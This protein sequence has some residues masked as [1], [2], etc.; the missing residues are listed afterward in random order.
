MP[1]EQAVF[2]A[3]IDIGKT[4][5]KVLLIDLSTG[6]EV[7]VRKTANIALAGPPFPHF[8]EPALWDFILASLRDIGAMHRIDAISITTHGACGA[9]VDAN[10][11]LVL[12]VLD[13]E[14]VGPDEL[15][16]QYE[17]LRPPFAETGSPRLPIGLNLGAQLFWLAQRFAHEFS[18][19]VHFLTW[20]QY[21]A[22]KLT[23]VAASEPTSLGCHTDLWDPWNGRFS[24]LVEQQDWQHLFP[25]VRKASAVLGPLKAEVAASTRLD[26][27]I[28]VH[29]GIHD[30]NASL[31]PYLDSTHQHFSV[32]STGTWMITLAVGGKAVS[33]DVAR[34]TLVNVNA[35]GHPTPTSRYMAGREFDEITCGAIVQPTTAD[36]NHLLSNAI[37]ALPSLHPDTG[38]FPGLKFAW[39]NGEPQNDGQRTCAASFYAA[40]MGAECLALIGADGPVFVEGPF[41]AN[42]EFLEMLA[43]ACGR[44]VIANGQTAG[45][46]LGAA[47]L[48]GPVGTMNLQATPVMPSSDTALKTYA[49]VWRQEV[50]RRWAK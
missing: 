41:G 34:D 12:P 44:P 20:P 46:G 3:V 29:C 18:R 22:M 16:A 15:A 26:K 11:N 36:R 45:T 24:S 37:M 31:L 50:Q 17:A 33:L 19:A 10:G 9:L 21:W 4:N 7:M 42:R 28:P 5:A 1:S 32:M 30:S 2:I 8:D 39:P 47:M 48:A 49:A 27:A 23:G 13:Y 43:T 35:K 25:E 14:H 38:P 40:L 6:S